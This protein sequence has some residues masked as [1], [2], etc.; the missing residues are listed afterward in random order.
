LK[1]GINLRVPVVEDVAIA[2]VVDLVEPR[3]V[4]R[5]PEA[6]R[7]IRRGANPEG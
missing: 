6:E 3:A 4:E 5:L 7:A 1:F 2:L